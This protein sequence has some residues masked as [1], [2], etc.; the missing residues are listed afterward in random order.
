LKVSKDLATKSL[1]DLAK[2]L[3]LWQIHLTLTLE[4]LFFGR[5]QNR[6]SL[7]EKNDFIWD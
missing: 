1:K 4:I 2:S 7:W 3:R 6:F 5:S